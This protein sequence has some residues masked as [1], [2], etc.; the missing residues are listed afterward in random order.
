MKRRKHEPGTWLMLIASYVHWHDIHTRLLYFYVRAA[1]KCRI[2]SGYKYLSYAGEPNT[3]P[4]SL[5][6]SRVK[7]RKPPN[8]VPS[9]CLGKQSGRAMMSPSP[10]TDLLNITTPITLVD[11]SCSLRYRELRRF[12]LSVELTPSEGAA[13]RNK[14][15]QH[16]HKRTPR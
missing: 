3:R 10:P 5:A 12:R 1:E 16:I 8:S 14:T 7:T 15:E 6:R 9:A 4:R 2:C 13:S 11:A